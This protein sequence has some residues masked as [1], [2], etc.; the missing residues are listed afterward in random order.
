MD[1]FGLGLTARRAGRRYVFRASIFFFENDGKSLSY[2]L[3]VIRKRVFVE[4]GKFSL[5]AKFWTK[6][7]KTPTSSIFLSYIP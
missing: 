7:P 6:M 4:T 2:N 5:D 1:N 3:K